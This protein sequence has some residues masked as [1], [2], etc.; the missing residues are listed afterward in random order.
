MKRLEY[1]YNNKIIGKLNKVNICVKNDTKEMINNE[2]VKN[3][4]DVFGERVQLLSNGI[5]KKTEMK[6]KRGG[7][8]ICVKNINNKDI[9]N[10]QRFRIVDYTEKEITIKNISSKIKYLLAKEDFNLNFDYGYAL[11]LYKIQGESVNI[12]D[13]GIFDWDIISNTGDYLYTCLSRIKEELIKK[14]DEYKYNFYYK[15]GF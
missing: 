10:S 5:K 1:D 12:A 8:V 9:Y 13:L 14:P 15:M 6:V 11:T 3:W 7:R 2:I 4:V